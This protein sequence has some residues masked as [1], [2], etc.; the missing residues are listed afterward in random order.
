M[1]PVPFKSKATEHG[2]IY[3]AIAVKKFE[4][5]F[6]DNL[7]ISEC[8]LFVPIDR[9]Y[10]GATPDR[11][12]FKKAVV[13]VKCLYT[14]RN[15]EIDEKTSPFLERDASNCLRL[16]KKHPYYYQMQGQ[17]YVT[18]R[19]VCEFVIYTFVDISVI[20]VKRDDDFIINILQK[21]DHFYDTYLKPALLEE[22]LYKNYGAAFFTDDVLKK[23]NAKR[24]NPSE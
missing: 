18:G 24:F 23:L 13:E 19:N 12:L 20:S 1:N 21:L 15:M 4:N 22:Y 9:P 11:L 7:E 2:K 8:G 10:L 16:K 5:I 14:N 3:E 6:E 17:L